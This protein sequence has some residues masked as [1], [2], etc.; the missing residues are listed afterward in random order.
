MSLS[1]YGPKIVNIFICGYLRAI[2]KKYTPTDIII[3]LAT[4]C[5]VIPE[6]ESYYN[7][8]SI[9]GTILNTKIQIDSNTLDI[10]CET[11][12]VFAASTLKEI[13]FHDKSVWFNF[14]HENRRIPYLMARNSWNK[15]DLIDIIDDKDYDHVYRFEMI[16][17]EGLFSFGL[18]F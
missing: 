16:L 3:L 1:L 18:G 2:I 4:Y 8:E 5:Q 10:D 6:F 13:Q 11:N 15:Q 12:E 17:K 9:D 14:K 7:I